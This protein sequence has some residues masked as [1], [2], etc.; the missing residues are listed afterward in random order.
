M[1]DPL[2]FATLQGGSS[3]LS[4]STIS[5]DNMQ[6][7]SPA[8]DVIYL[9]FEP[10]PENV[11]RYGPG[12]GGTPINQAEYEKSISNVTTPRT[13]GKGTFWDAM[14]DELLVSRYQQS[15]APN[16]FI[17]KDNR[18]L[19]NYILTFKKSGLYTNILPSINYN[20]L[21]DKYTERIL[22]YA[23]TYNIP[24]LEM[25]ADAYKKKFE[26]KYNQV[27]QKI[28]EGNEKVGKSD[29]NNLAN[30]YRSIKYFGDFP[31]LVS[32]TEILV[33]LLR[34][35]NLTDKNITAVNGVLEEKD[36]VW[37][38]IGYEVDN[39]PEEEKDIVKNKLRLLK[40]KLNAFVNETEKNS[41][42]EHQEEK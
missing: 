35:L 22:K 38:S 17:Q 4:L 28:Q 9:G 21:H 6:F 13:Q 39:L 34:D 32:E 3:R 24:I 40:E 12:D 10:K 31:G 42:L 18:I 30:Y 33:D 37:K 26:E 7:M 11:L 23:S 2:S 20:N 27:K 15:D 29:F 5:D 41:S 19:P 25:D 1:D 16:K 14:Y 8:K 36:G